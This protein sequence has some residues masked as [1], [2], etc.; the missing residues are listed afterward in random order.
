MKSFQE[1]QKE[2]DQLEKSRQYLPEQLQI[3]KYA[4]Y[5]PDFDETLLFNPTIPSEYMEIYVQLKTMRKIDI[6]GYILGKWH[7]LGF[8]PKQLYLLIVAHAQ[9]MDISRITSNMSEEEIKE[10]LNKQKKQDIIDKQRKES[11]MPKEEIEKIK[12]I[13]FSSE[14]ELFLLR[15][16]ESNEIDALLNSQLKN[17]SLEQ[18]KYLY[19]V[20]STGTSIEQIMNPNLSVDEMKSIALTGNE[21]LK[22]FQEIQDNHIKREK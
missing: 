17:C 14:V 15:V 2:L 10:F 21:S 13:G 16:G 5:R 1:V 9:N 20:Y 3:I 18:M 8:N 11:S 12:S 22:F 7:L 6:K 19:A 4:A